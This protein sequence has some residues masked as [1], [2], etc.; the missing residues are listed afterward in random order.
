MASTGWFDFYRRSDQVFSW[1]LNRWGTREADTVYS[2][3]GEGWDFLVRAKR[4]GARVALDVFITPITHRIVEAER[5]NFSGWERPDA[6]PHE[7][8]EEQLDR[9][10]RVADVLLCPSPTVVD[11]LRAYP[12]FDAG[13]IRLV[14]YGHAVDVVAGD[15]S[16]ETTRK[17]LFGGAAEL[18]KGIHYYCRAAEIL[19][20]GGRQVEF[21]AAG[22]ASEIVRERPEARCV[23]FLGPL[24][25]PD[26]LKELRSSSVFVLP[27]LAE[28]S[29]SV[30][31][32]ALCS[33]VPVVTTRSAGS[34]VT[35]GKDGLIV[36]ER[37]PEA[38]AEAIREIVSD[39]E[40]RASMRAHALVTAAEYTEDRWQERLVQALQPPSR[41]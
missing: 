16:E 3:M 34:V 26:F 21:V 35:D 5:R 1:A 10:F 31:F 14:P 17:V 7:R 40:L 23:R 13:K 4:G 41:N 33:G 22:P 8:I 24:R 29:A 9:R 25:R 2:M 28:G 20:R 12:S 27:T 30:I 6:T 36:P 39:R 37:D 11:G 15:S 19:A 32:E 38:L 18:R